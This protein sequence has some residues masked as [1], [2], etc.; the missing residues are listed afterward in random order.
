MGCH[1]PLQGIFP[2]QGWSNLG[3]QNCRQTLYHLSQESGVCGSGWVFLKQWSGSRRTGGRT[4][5]GLNILAMD[6]SQ[7]LR[8]DLLF[9]LTQLRSE[10][11]GS[12]QG[13]QSLEGSKFLWERARSPHPPLY[14]PVFCW[15][16]FQ[17]SP[18]SDLF[19]PLHWDVIQIHHVNLWKSFPT[20]PRLFKNL[21]SIINLIILTSS[22]APSL[23]S[24][25]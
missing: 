21:M 15:V 19:S 16:S 18:S 25:I 1:S 11:W 4:G 14:L 20:T 8:S 22:S 2:T 6:D 10:S 13:F 5:L 3:F 17:T 12:R 9:M 7:S 23:S 24:F